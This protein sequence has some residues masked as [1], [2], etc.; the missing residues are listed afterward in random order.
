V[1]K[2]LLPLLLISACTDAGLY[3]VGAGG[4]TGPDRAEFSGT[5]CAP[6]AAGEAFPV[7][8]VFV[9][10]G[11]AGVD[12]QVVGSVVDALNAVTAQFSTPY[13]SFA[14]VGYHTVATGFQGSFARDSQIATAI[15]KYGSFQETGPLSHRSALKLAGT[16]MGGDMQTACRG[17]VARTRY[18]VVQVIMDSDTSCANL[19]F[20]AGVNDRCTGFLTACTN[21]S[22]AQCEQARAQC[23]ECELAATTFELKELGTMFGAGEVSVQ[24]VYVR[25]TPNLVTR[26]QAAAIARAGGT[27]LIEVTPDAVKRTLGSLNYASLQRPLTLKRLVVLNRNTIARKAATLV[28]SDGDG[29]SDDE[30]DAIGTDKLNVDSDGDRLSDGVELR[31]GLTPQAGTMPNV[32]QACN[33]E[34]DADGDRLNDCEERVLGTDA[35]VTDSDGD[36]LSDLVEFLAQTNSLVADDLNDADGDGRPN[37]D[38]VAQ[39]TDALS[40]DLA[41]ARERGYGY[42]IQEAKPTE[43]GRACYDVNLFNITLVPTLQRNSPDGS[44]AII[45]K[46]TNDIYVYFQVGHENDPRGTGIG[47]L[48]VQPIKFTPPGT[49]KPKGVIRFSSDDFV[50]G[51]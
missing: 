34:N 39:H 8:V 31:A 28:D 27:E 17:L 32:I 33:T 5:I 9:L 11:G 35:C 49:K 16:I 10:Q 46:G 37:V 24:P 19:G 13:I 18:Y 47:S 15:A 44:G 4:P 29:V 30:E 23:S 7:K 42:S 40:A 25:S 36:G 26:Y 48:F 3:A 50:T 38:E 45:Q 41:F 20:N 12:R 21:G 14:I 22:A 1:R 2:F 51:Y 6:L 43:D